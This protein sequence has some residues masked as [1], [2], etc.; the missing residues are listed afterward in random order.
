MDSPGPTSGE[1]K[2]QYRA[3]D[4]FGNEAAWDSDQNFVILYDITDPIAGTTTVNYPASGWFS[5]TYPPQLSW[6][7]WS[8]AHAGIAYYHVKLNNN[9][10][11]NLSN[12]TTSY[13]HNQWND[14][15]CSNQNKFNLSAMT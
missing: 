12:T 5:E 1:Y 9:M 3:V 4:R 15:A 13:T 7:G 2:F 11:S 14:L 8:D 10:V 6:T